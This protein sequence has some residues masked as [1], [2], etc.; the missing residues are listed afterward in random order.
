[1]AILYELHTLTTDKCI[2][3][4]NTCRQQ[5]DIR[6]HCTVCEDFDLCE[7]CYNI[8]SNHEHKM[9][10]YNTLNIN[11]KSSIITYC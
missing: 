5:C 10:K 11:D 1:M 8:E 2:Y 6:Y 9:D 4:C 7:K 3:N